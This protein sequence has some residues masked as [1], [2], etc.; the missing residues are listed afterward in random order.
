MRPAAQR[1]ALAGLAAPA[2]LVGRHPDQLRP[3]DPPCPGS[4]APA[5]D[6][7]ESFGRAGRGQD[8]RIPALARIRGTFAAPQRMSRPPRTSDTFIHCAA[9]PAASPTPSRDPPPCRARL[10]RMCGADAA[11]HPPFQYGRARADRARVAGPRGR[12]GWRGRGRGQ[13]GSGRVGD[14]ANLGQERRAEG[15]AAAAR[16]SGTS[17]TWIEPSAGARSAGRTRTRRSSAW[18]CLRPT[19]GPCV[20][21]RARACARPRVRA[22]ASMKVNEWGWGCGWVGVEDD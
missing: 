20:R 11:A 3:G 4:I 12:G 1:A 21:L 14:V 9:R 22:C 15:D 18:H 6:P 19:R 8:R 2:P 5:P 17:I 10:H 13:T 7:S 16:R